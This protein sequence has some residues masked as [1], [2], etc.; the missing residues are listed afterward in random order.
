MYQ[1]LGVSRTD[2]RKGETMRRMKEEG[3]L[4]VRADPALLTV[5][6]LASS[7]LGSLDPLHN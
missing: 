2:Q 3:E 1:D 6:H 4:V 5:G 7:P